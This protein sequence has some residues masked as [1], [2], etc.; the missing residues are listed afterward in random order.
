[1]TATNVMAWV[2]FAGQPAELF[3]GQATDGTAKQLTTYEAGASL[4]DFAGQTVTRI[5]AQAGDGS[6]LSVMQLVDA[7]GGELGQW[8]GNERMSAAGS[9]SNQYNIKTQR[10]AILVERGSTLMVTTAD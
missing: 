1:M 9:N 4:G 6:I 2:E 5:T 10:I 8:I 3:T 7:A